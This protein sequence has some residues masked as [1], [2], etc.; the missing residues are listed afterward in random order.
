MVATVKTADRW[1]VCPDYAAGPYTP[2]AVE[3]KLGQCEQ[4]NCPH[5]GRHQIVISA[6]K[7]VTLTELHTLYA[8]WSEPFLA[9]PGDVHA[10]DQRSADTAE[11]AAAILEVGARSTAP[12]AL[13]SP[14]GGF[15]ILNGGGWS[16]ETGDTADKAGRRGSA[17]WRAALGPYEDTTLTADGKGAIRDAWCRCGTGA[18]GWVQYQAWTVQGVDAHGFVCGTC[19]KITQ[20]G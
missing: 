2:A 10:C 6:Q 15:M 13:G 3:R 8:N 5:T 11:L 17:E 20:T 4:S 16:K 19:R 18:E 9:D 14:D 12:I 1:V 7:P